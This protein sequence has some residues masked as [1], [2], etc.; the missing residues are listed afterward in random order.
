MLRQVA[1]W[2]NSIQERCVQC[3][4][5][6]MKNI[7]MFDIQENKGVN[8]PIFP[9]PTESGEFHSLCII[10]G[11]FL[12]QK[13][14]ASSFQSGN[15]IKLFAVETGHL[16]QLATYNVNF[17]PRRLLWI[18]KENLLLVAHWLENI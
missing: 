2:P 12:N 13:I 14:I 1:T 4:V 15:A 3:S 9:I 8:D 6:C 16:T 11:Q 17:P 10:S 5:V 7:Y 18:Q